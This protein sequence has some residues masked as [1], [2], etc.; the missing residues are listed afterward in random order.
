MTSSALAIVIF[1]MTL[2]IVC[3]PDGLVIGPRRAELRDSARAREKAGGAL[4]VG[5]DAG[6]AEADGFG[7][8]GEVA[9]AAGEA[10]DARAEELLGL[11]EVLVVAELG[12][13]PGH[14]AGA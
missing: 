13:E 9:G 2:P 12:G 4:A 6:D 8:A 5:G 11:A 1:S 7:G 3:L 10:L 14:A